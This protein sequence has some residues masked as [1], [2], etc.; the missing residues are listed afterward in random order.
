MCALVP[1]GTHANKR[2]DSNPAVC[3]LHPNFYSSWQ[4]MFRR[5]LHNAGSRDFVF[6]M[7][8]FV[9]QSIE[10]FL[11]SPGTHSWHHTSWNSNSH[12]CQRCFKS[13]TVASKLAYFQNSINMSLVGGW[14][15][16]WDRQVGQWWT[17][18]QSAALLRGGSAGEVYSEKHVRWS[19]FA[20]PPL[21]PI[22]CPE[23]IPR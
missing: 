7:I 21:N 22:R 15:D 13:N 16:S 2:A 8:D 18:P 5:L 1:T 17:V 9:I 23:A 6:C 11:S 19:K 4:D 3:R 20:P 10:F 12:V 14:C